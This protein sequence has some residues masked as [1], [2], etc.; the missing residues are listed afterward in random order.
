[1]FLTSP[2]IDPDDSTNSDLIDRMR[3]RP[4]LCSPDQMLKTICRGHAPA[5]SIQVWQ[6]TSYPEE[7]HC[8]VGF[9]TPAPQIVHPS[10]DLGSLRPFPYLAP[11]PAAIRG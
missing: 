2:Y 10:A 3:I 5:L 1:M 9:R 8:A 4:N 6:F 7:R 11:L